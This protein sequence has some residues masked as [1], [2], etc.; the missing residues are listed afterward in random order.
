VSAIHRFGRFE[1]HA[2]EEILLA[3]GQPVALGRCAVRLLLALVEQPGRVVCKSELLDRVWP[4]RVVV[5]NNIQVQVSVLRKL[6]GTN[7]IATVPGRGYRFLPP[8]DEGGTGSAAHAP[9][10]AARALPALVAPPLGRDGEL[11][12]LLHLLGN[13][14]KVTLS[15]S[16]GIGKT[17][18]AL[19]CAHAMQDRLRDGAAWVD[20]ASLGDPALVG[21]AVAQALG[22]PAFDG[23]L[24]PP[25]DALAPL[26]LLLVLDNAEHLL[27]AVAAMVQAVIARAPGVRVLV[28]SQAMLRVDGERVFRLGGL[29]VPEEGCSPARALEH[30]ALALLVEHAQAADRRFRI[31]ERNVGELVRICRRLDGVPLA[32]RL[33][34][35][36]LPQFGA[37][38]VSARLDKDAL[39]LLCNER[40]DAGPRQQAVAAAICWSHTLLV[41]AEQRVLRRLSVFAGGFTLE[42]AR[43]VASEDEGLGPAAIDDLVGALVERS[44]VESD[45]Q[46]RPRYR[47]LESVRQFAQARLDQHA[48]RAAVER[49]HAQALADAMDDAYEA[50]W[51]SPDDAWRQRH[52]PDLDNVRAALDACA[53]RL[54]DTALLCRLVGAASVLFL[55][56]GLAAEGRRYGASAEPLLAGEPPSPALARF[57]LERSR[58]HW[59]IS[60]DAMAAYA[61]RAE[62]LCRAIGDTRGLFLALRCCAGCPSLPMDQRERALAELTALEQ[63]EWPPRLRAQRML[64]EAGVA[65]AAGRLEAAAGAFESLVVFAGDTGLESMAS[66]AASGLAAVKFALGDDDAALAWSRRLLADGGPRSDNFVLHA[67][68]TAAA[69]CLACGRIDDGRAAVAEFLQRARR[70]DWEWLG[71]HGDLLALLAACEGRI[72]AACRLA[73]FADAVWNGLGEREPESCRMNRLVR[74][75]VDDAGMPSAEQARWRALGMGLSAE[76]VASLALARDREAAGPRPSAGRGSG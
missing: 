25:V 63:P 26:E 18:L 7:A 19:T 67:L 49:R 38:G 12:E 40:R 1:L 61:R 34:A 31:D 72:D 62:A 37:Q 13:C 23:S 14:R 10:R 4:G 8:A 54:C 75:R 3:D 76:S 6:L 68:A 47:L 70:R 58:L 45:G 33:A 43:A 24:Q 64:A 16:P 15:G 52:A 74:T 60:N 44:L 9:S 66:A 73:G 22:V 48:E 32:L 42:L 51:C 53:R 56:L 57:W 41:P 36:R 39:S 29:A 55:V 65:K 50:W 27:D 5:E 59:G 30:P 35:A 17:L 69:A 21:G 2:R 20:L 46:E 11:A 28:T 71:L